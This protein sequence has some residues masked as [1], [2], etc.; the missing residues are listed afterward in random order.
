MLK[1]LTKSR[2]GSHLSSVRSHHVTEAR[3]I[4]H[5]NFIQICRVSPL[6]TPSRVVSLF[7]RVANISR[8]V[9]AGYIGWMERMVTW[10]FLFSPILSVC[11]LAQGCVILLSV[12][13]RMQRMCFTTI[14]NLT[15]LWL[16]RS[17]GGFYPSGVYGDHSLNWKANDITLKEFVSAL[18]SS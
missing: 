14:K 11:W 16:C 5:T 17:V 7:V 3:N 13:K 6:Q 18:L 9:T 2:R 15:R 10:I 1:N 8:S 12:L 4:F